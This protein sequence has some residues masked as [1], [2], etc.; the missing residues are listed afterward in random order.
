M[1]KLA[2]GV[3]ELLPWEQK[4]GTQ[5]RGSISAKLIVKKSGF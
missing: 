1:V 3:G 5:N 2:T 4:R